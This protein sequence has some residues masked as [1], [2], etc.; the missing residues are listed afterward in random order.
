[1]AVDEAVGLANAGAKVTFLGATGPTCAELMNAPLKV[2]NLGQEP[3]SGSQRRPRVMLQALWNQAAFSV[4]GNLLKT[5]NPTDTVVHVHGYTKSLSA[6]PIKSATDRGFHVVCTLHDF[7]SACPNGAFFN[8]SDNK[9]CHLKGLSSPCI[10][11]NCDK[12]HFAHKL[13]RVARS[14][15]QQHLGNFPTG[16]R[17]YIALSNR[18]IEVLRPYLPVGANVFSLANPIKI[19]PRAPS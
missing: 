2:I 17:N 11:T 19:E 10:T 4:M 18:S 16:V 15:A 8:F 6:S 3:L 5:L 7:F 13:Y 14:L 9:L 12:R 1:M